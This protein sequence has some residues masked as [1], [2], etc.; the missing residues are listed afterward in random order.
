[1]RFCRKRKPRFTLHKT[2]INVPLSARSCLP[3]KSSRIF[4]ERSEGGGNREENPRKSILCDISPG[5]PRLRW[6]Q[7]E[8]AERKC[9]LCVR[10]N[11][12]QPSGCAVTDAGAM[13]RK[14][15]TNSFSL[16][17]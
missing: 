10:K 12:L 2:L 13:G 4:C 3:C 9:S 11:I 5:T 6:H 7:K 1:M 16:T 14:H 8:K 17:L 15:S